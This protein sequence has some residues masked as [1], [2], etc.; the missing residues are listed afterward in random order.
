MALQFVSPKPGRGVPKV[1]LVRPVG[2]AQDLAV[3]RTRKRCHESRIL[4]PADN[5]TGGNFN[6]CNRS[7]P[8]TDKCSFAV[9]APFHT[10]TE[11]RPIHLLWSR[12][13]PN[14]DPSRVV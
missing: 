11:H 13:V 7:S 4:K 8:G 10:G 12:R 9:R 6:R 1:H 3:G 5:P 14:G 2:S